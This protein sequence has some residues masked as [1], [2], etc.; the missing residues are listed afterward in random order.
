M[1]SP[2]PP[3][4]SLD[5]DKIGR[6][7]AGEASPDEAAAVRRWLE[8]HP[9]DAQLVATLDAGIKHAAPERIDVEAA[10][11]RVKTRA[12]GSTSGALWKYAAFV[13]A[14]AIILLVGLT[15]TR[16]RPAVDVNE[17]ARQYATGIGQRD[18]IILADGS[19]VVLGPASWIFASGNG[20]SVQVNGEAYFDVVHDTTRPFTVVTENVLIRDVGTKFPVHTDSGPPVRVVVNEGAV[21]IVVGRRDSVALA[22]GD[23]AV[24]EGNGRVDVQ[25]GA[26]SADDLAFTRGRL[27][28]RDASMAELA[29]DL[30][31]WYGVELRVS[32]TALL[33]RH[34]TGSF[35][36]EPSG[37]VLDV[38]ALALN[39]RV[40]RRGDTAFIRPSS[41]SP[42]PR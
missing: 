5:W 6:Y 26:A 12:R 40:D 13:A 19:R 18:S 27:V 22:A 20:R 25:R 4:P 3:R 9:G 29:A 24:V 42:A 30:H 36:T 38:I 28:F 35:E 23:V 32:D 10:L 34:F 2:R 14:A 11:Q 41:G 15:I 39:A 37:R 17:P 1:T 21:R 7:L 8:E 31:R 33:R 16:R